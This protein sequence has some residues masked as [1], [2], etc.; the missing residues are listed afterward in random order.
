MELFKKTAEK[1]L[2]EFRTRLEQERTQNFDA[3]ASRK[4]LEE[5]LSQ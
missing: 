1:N 4:K 2:E 5:S 3:S